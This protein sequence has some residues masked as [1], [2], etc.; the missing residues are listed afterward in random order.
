M[1][2]ACS[3]CG[4]NH[5]RGETCN[6]RIKTKRK[7]KEANFINVFRSS[8]AWKKK[9]EEIK[10]RDRFFC[11]ICLLNKYWTERQYNYKNLEVHHILPLRNYFDKRLQNS[12]L[13]TLCEF[14]HTLAEDG[15]I[16]IDELQDIALKNEISM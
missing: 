14:H 16:S 3:F 9:R 13:I 1:L 11:Q 12:N 5:N 2:V 10:K 8:N 6:R 4:R 7:A 15:K